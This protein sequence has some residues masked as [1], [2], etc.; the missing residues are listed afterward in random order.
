MKTKQFLSA[1]AIACGILVFAGNQA[2]A[3]STP[4]KAIG[5]GDKTINVATHYLQSGSVN[6]KITN[7]GKTYYFNGTGSYGVS[8]VQLGSFPFKGTYFDVEVTLNNPSPNFWL[9]A[10]PPFFQF[11]N[12]YALST[13][14]TWSDD[15]LNDAGELIIVFR[16]PY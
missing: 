7:D 6:V 16:N 9:L 8:Q 5:F 4:E 10:G 3:Q 11:E 2:F 12:Q 13:R 1:V 15:D 14:V